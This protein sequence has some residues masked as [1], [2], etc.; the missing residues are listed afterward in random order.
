[1]RKLRRG[2]DERNGSELDHSGDPKSI[3][4]LLLRPAHGSCAVNVLMLLQ[5]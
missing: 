1:M 2:E 4:L 3:P 5:S